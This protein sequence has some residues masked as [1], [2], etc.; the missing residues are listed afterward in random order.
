M[1]AWRL[2]LAVPGVAALGYAASRLWEV[3]ADAW[4]S[5]LTWL[6]GGVLLHDAVLAPIVIG[7][8][9]AASRWLPVPWRS[10]AVVALVWWGS[11]TLAA[12]PVLYGG[13]VR[14]DNPTLLDRPY[15]ASWWLGSATVVVLVVAV[16]WWRR[17]RSTRPGSPSHAGRTR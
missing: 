4:G 2:A 16:G 11:L 13:G 10:P 9:V 1:T 14:P 17:L 8:G 15:V 6:A 7:L 3:P 5:V 12:I